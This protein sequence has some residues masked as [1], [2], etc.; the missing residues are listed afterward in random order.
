MKIENAEARPNVCHPRLSGIFLRRKDCGRA[1]M[2]KTDPLASESGIALV[3]VL[4]LSAIALAIMAALVFMITASTQISGIQ[5]RYKTALEA[6]KGG[7][8]LT[9][10]LIATRGNLSITGLIDPATNLPAGN[11]TGTDGH[12]NPTDCL[13][14]KMNMETDLWPSACNTSPEID[15]TNSATYDMF[16]DLGT[17]PT[18][19][20]YGKIVDTVNGNSGADTGL[21][22]SGVVS[23][24]SGEVTPVSMPYLYTIEVNAV[25]TNNP[26]ERARYSIL[27]QY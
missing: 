25:N 4:I 12:G 8:D 19:R 10:Q 13:T 6:G 1:A 11:I 20:V 21:Q 22:K 24:N 27:Y 17:V 2:T 15:P 18:F 3:M 16:F 14:A 5:K 7:A 23:S 9:F 26:S